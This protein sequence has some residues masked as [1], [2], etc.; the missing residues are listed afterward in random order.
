[1][2]YCFFIFNLTCKSTIN[3][4]ESKRLADL[5]AVKM[6]TFQ[7]RFTSGLFVTRLNGANLNFDINYSR[8]YVLQGILKFSRNRTSQRNRDA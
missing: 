7:T 6:F 5:P 1:M 4:T 3:S 8:Q 2:N